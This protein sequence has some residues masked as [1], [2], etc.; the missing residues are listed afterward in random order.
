M[1]RSVAVEA[2]SVFDAPELVAFLDVLLTRVSAGKG[3]SREVLQEMALEPVV[4]TDLPYDHLRASYQ[5]AR[6]GGL[7]QVAGFF[8]GSPVLPRT[9]ADT[10]N[11]QHLDMPLG[12]RRSAARASDRFTLDRLVH[13]RNP[14]VIALLLNNPRLV[15]RDV[16]KIA[17]G[18][19]TNA[20]VLALVAGHRKWAS[21]YRVRKALAC[22]PYTPA[23]IARRLLPTLMRQDL[24]DLQ[25]SKVLSAEL[26]TL[27]WGLIRRE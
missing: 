18:R 27:A 16:I 3:A 2:I 10:D 13:D 5:V 15:E 19:P 24:R 20:E 25:N 4:F 23:P 1:R 14:K 26:R 6:D 7:L 12:I 11:N 22:N 17:A 8:L 9:V 21:S